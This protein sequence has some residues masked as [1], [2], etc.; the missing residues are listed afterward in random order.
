MTP[1]AKELCDTWER[2]HPELW[3]RCY[4]R[5][6]QGVGEFESPRFVALSIAAAITWLERSPQTA[7]ISMQHLAFIASRAFDFGLPAFFVAREFF[8]AINQTELP[9]DLRWTDAK[10]PHEAGLLYLPV[11]ALRD[12]EG[13]SVNI[14]AWMRMRAGEEI[15]IGERVKCKAAFGGEDDSFMVAAICQSESERAYSRA[16]AASQTPYIVAPTVLIPGGDGIFDLPITAD[17]EVFLSHMVA[18][19]FSLLLS[20]HAKPELLTPGCRAEGKKTKK[21]QRE[22]WTPNVIGKNYMVKREHQGGNHAS[23]RYHWRRGHFRAQR[24]GAGL[25][26]VKTIWLEPMLIGGNDEGEQKT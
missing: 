1:T 20:I 22:I 21:A 6:Y 15:M 5:A 26:Q 10:L 4:P 25:Q 17:D 23:P 7:P 3:K 9:N 13:T 24:H 18:V 14:L 16:V 19:C 8:A 12:L 2:Q 11:G